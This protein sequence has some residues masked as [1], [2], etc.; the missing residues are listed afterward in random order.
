MSAV[1]LTAAQKKAYYNKCRDDIEFYWKHEF[2]IKPRGRTTVGDSGLINMSPLL[3]GQQKA[4]DIIK[5]AYVSGKP[6][7]LYIYKHRKGGFSTLSLGICSHMAAFVNNSDSVVVSMDDQSTQTLRRIATTASK[8]HTKGIGFPRITHDNPK[9]FEYANESSL[10]IFTAGKGEVGRGATPYFVLSSELAFWPNAKTT[11][12]GL[13]NSV[14]VDSAIMIYESTSNGT[15]GRGE[16]WYQ[17]YLDIKEGRSRAHTIFVGWHEDPRNAMEPSGAEVDIFGQWRELYEAGDVLAEKYAQQ[18]NQ[19]IRF[20]K[21]EQD[22]VLEDGISLPQLRW[23]DEIL[24]ESSGA[25]SF[26]ERIVNRAQEY[27]SN[28]EESFRS[29]GNASFDRM[30]LQIML[31]QAPKSFYG[32][33]EAKAVTRGDPILPHETYDQVDEEGNLSVSKP[34]DFWEMQDDNAFRR[35]IVKRME[36]IGNANT[37]WWQRADGSIYVIAWVPEQG[38]KATIYEQPIDGGVYFAGVDTAQGIEKDSTSCNILRQD[39][40]TKRLFQVARYSENAEPPETCAVVVWHMLQFYNNPLCVPETNTIGQIMLKTL[41]S[42]GYTNFYRQE[43][44]DIRAKYASQWGFN[45][46]RGSRGM[47]VHLTKQLL[48]P[49]DPLLVLRDPETIKQFMAMRRDKGKDDHPKGY[50]NDDWVS[51]MLAAMGAHKPPE[52]ELIEIRSSVMQVKP[53]N[54]KERHMQ[55][56]KLAG[57]DRTLGKYR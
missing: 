11:N 30:K 4:W 55:N 26:D 1:K 56:E 43:K 15:T 5:P 10:Q 54:A 31:D 28:I 12:L 50:H 17:M 25:G 8:N 57:L 51:V 46:D 36:Q 38:A 39:P 29:A 35:G 18:L 22:L 48:R 2:K 45:T 14:D 3:P 27:P 42:M 16:F 52:S 40:M 20:T 47:L 53:Q 37:R 33:F 19:T 41:Q 7:K 6:C 24:R 21:Y 34:P 49:A 44:M 9:F 23:Y 13:T 32:G